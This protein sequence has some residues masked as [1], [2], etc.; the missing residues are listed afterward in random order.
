M[1]DGAV[2]FV[3][4]FIESGNEGATAPTTV[5]AA[6]P[7]GVWGSLGSRSGGEVPVMP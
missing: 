5:T 3:S 4:E 2:L 7:Y 6:S 1:G